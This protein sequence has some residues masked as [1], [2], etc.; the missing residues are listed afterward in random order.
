MVLSASYM[1]LLHSL[2]IKNHPIY[3]LDD[4]PLISEVVLSQLVSEPDR[5]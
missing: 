2:F 1:C 5:G 3:I 4:V